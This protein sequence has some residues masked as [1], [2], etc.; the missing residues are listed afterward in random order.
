MMRVRGARA[1]AR[2][3]TPLLLDD[4][5]HVFADF[6]C[7]V[8][9]GRAGRP[10]TGRIKVCSRSLIVDPDAWDTPVTRLPY[11]SMSHMD[12][13]MRSGAPALDVRCRIVVEMKH[14]G[15]DTPYVSRESIDDNWK[16]T[17][18][19]SDLGLE[20]PLIRRLFELRHDV[21]RADKL[22]GIVHERVQMAVFDT[23][24][25]SDI[26]ERLLTPKAVPCNVITP[27]QQSLSVMMLT[28][29]RLYV[30]PIVQDA[31]RTGGSCCVTSHP[32]SKVT[33][34]FRRRYA[35]RH[36][37]LEVFIGDPQGA[38]VFLAFDDTSVRDSI[39]EMIAAHANIP[40]Q[41][42]ARELADEWSSGVL[43][44]FDYILA[45]NRLSGRSFN[46]FTAYPVFPWVIADYKSQNLDL[47]NPDTYRDLSKPMGAVNAERLAKF[48]ERYKEMPDDQPKFLYGTHYS[49]PGYVVYYLVREQPAYM[50]TLQG[51][52]FDSPDRLFVSVAETWESCNRNQADV[53]ELIPQFYDVSCTPRFLLES[54][55]F[56]GQRQDGSAIGAVHLPPWA[57]GDPRRFVSLLRSALESDHVRQHLNEWIDLV[58]GFKQ[59][60]QEAIDADNV[61]YHLTYEGSVDLDSIHSETERQCLLSQIREFGQTPSQLFTEPHPRYQ[62]GERAPHSP[63]P[64]SPLKAAPRD[65]AAAAADSASADQIA[66]MNGTEPLSGQDG[67]RIA[68]QYTL[69]RFGVHQGGVTGVALDPND[70][71]TVV[72]VS[73]DTTLKVFDRN[74]GRVR[75][76]CRLDD[77]GFALSCVTMSAKDAVCIA[78]SWSNRLHVY[79]VSAGQCIDS[80]A[81][82]H[83]DIVT[84]VDLYDSRLL[85]SA[86][87]DASVKLW[88]LRPS[89]IAST[90]THVLMEHESGVVAVR[91][92]DD[93]LVASVDQDG[94]VLVWDTRTGCSSHCLTQVHKQPVTGLAWIGVDLATCSIDG[95]LA[96]GSVSARRPLHQ[97]ALAEPLLSLSID[98][99]LR[100]YCGARSGAVHV[101]N[102]IDDI[103][104]Q[105]LSGGTGPIVS[106][107]TCDDAVV[108]AVA[109]DGVVAIWNRLC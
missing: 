95:T 64:H 11:A 48:R 61:F 89:G 3:F 108:A 12:L 34:V 57:E 30:Q 36:I 47:S 5:E 26:K 62:G 32:I 43:S 76:S 44:N 51:G 86:S 29:S 7:V 77:Q 107:A 79:S 99:R 105:T 73:L 2:R 74:D 90:P 87:K 37:G 25:I 14:Q 97:V 9:A 100:L 23:S 98:S 8:V 91:F 28:D 80:V 45:L 33:E 49:T 68:H 81:H 67:S 78:G 35:M 22:A 24:A 82:A 41:K 53:K 16:V 60:G 13:S 55:T 84:A 4:G 17:L 85:A 83:D 59:R 101:C 102:G 18:P 39:Y 56:L 71:S 52:K 75:R 10:C 42:S 31:G 88:D 92:S 69:Q 58:F 66:A 63:V 6:E 46:D 1:K 20:F 38:S 40:G 109:G 21:D 103:P 50:L 27:L 15:Q 94:V 72:S 70:S 54:S 19:Y 106:L 93:G 65:N 96:I 104:V